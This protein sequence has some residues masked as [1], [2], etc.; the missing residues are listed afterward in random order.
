VKLGKLAPRHDART[1]QLANYLQPSV[2]P[3]IPT[4]QDWSGKVPQ[5]LMLL[6]D[7]LGCC[8]I[9]SI[10]HQIMAWTANASTEFIVSDHDVLK[11]YSAVSGYN[12]ATGEN[13]NGAVELDV[14]NY[15]RKKGIARHKISAYAALQPRNHAL[16]KAACYLFGGVYIGLALPLS[17]RNQAIWDI[18]KHGFSGNGRP[19]SWGG[20]AVSVTSFDEH[21][22]TCVTWGELKK[23]SWSF[24]S[25]YCDEAYAVLS[26]DFIDAKGIAPNA[27]DWDALQQDLKQI[28]H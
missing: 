26:K 27:F 21:Y 1:L 9:S 10:G 22:I 24:L 12:P 28:V 4:S 25:H 11:A 20:H 3:K 16:V 6:N 14:L 15:W 2:L 7:T 17:A 13:D 18:P 5:W 23:M 8:T 19:G